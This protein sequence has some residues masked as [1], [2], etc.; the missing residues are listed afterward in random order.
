MNIKIESYNQLKHQ[1]PLSET[2]QLVS[3]QV[4]NTPNDL[5]DT[6]ILNE[7]F[8]N[9]IDI[10]ISEDKKIHSKA[11]LLGIADRVY[12]IQTFLEKV[13]AEN[14][15]LIS[16][17]VLAVKKVDFGEVEIR[18]SFF[19][20]FR[21]DYQEFDKW[22]NSKSEQPCYVCYSDNQLTL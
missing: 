22:F 21:I 2:I 13:T 10:L 11:K 19:D 20:S 18:D 9:R 17:K 7:V 14:P 8:E 6:Q 4:D 5:N 16:H 1:A 15:D 12:R 3:N